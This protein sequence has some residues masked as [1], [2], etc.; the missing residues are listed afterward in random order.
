MSSFLDRLLGRRDPTSADLAK[1]RLKLVLVTDRSNI[2][3]D[4]LERMQTEIIQVIKKYL[5]IDD[6]Q[7]NIN[8]EQR[9]RKTY[10]VANVP[11]ERDHMYRLGPEEPDSKQDAPAPSSPDSSPDSSEAD[12]DA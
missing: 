5:Q 6:A 8:L 7:V 4:K 11:L 10:L 9:D 1:E 2:A 12:E 3:P